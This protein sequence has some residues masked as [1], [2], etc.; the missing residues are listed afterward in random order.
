MASF[1]IQLP[2]G[3]SYN[4]EAPDGTTD[5]QAYMYLQQSL[6]AEGNQ[7]AGRTEPIEYGTEA[8]YES[9]NPS[10]QRDVADVGVQFV[11]GVNRAAGALVGLGSY[12]KGLNKI[13][14]PAAAWFNKVADTVDEGLLSDRQKE[15]NAELG[16]RLQAAAEELGPDASMGDYIDNMVSQGGEAGQYIADHPTQ[17]INLAVQSLPYIFGGGIAS[18]AAKGSAKLLGLKPIANLG[19]TGSAAMGEG[20]IVGGQAVTDVIA[21]TDSVGDYSAD[22][23]K[24]L[25]TIP[26]TM[27]ISMLGGKASRGLGI[28]DVDTLL[29]SGQGVKRIVS[30]AG[31]TKKVIGGGLIEGTE[32]LFQGAGEQIGVNYAKTEG[33]NILN[34][35][36]LEDVGG[37]AVIGAFTGAGQ[38][39]V[40][41]LA[42]GLGGNTELKQAADEAQATAAQEARQEA[43]DNQFAELASAVNNEADIAALAETIGVSVEELVQDPRF[44]EAQA[45][46]Q[47]AAEL[48]VAKDQRVKHKDTMPDEKEWYNEETAARE[49]RARIEVSDETTEMGAAFVQWRK[50]N[51]VYDT[52][53]AVVLDWIRNNASTE[54]TTVTKDDF[55]GALDAHAALAEVKATRSEE[56]QFEINATLEELLAQ[57]TEALESGDME[58]LRLVEQQASNSVDPTEWTETKREAAIRTAGLNKNKKKPKTAPVVEPNK[59]LEGS[60]PVVTETI[61]PETVVVP[62]ETKVKPPYKP[63]SKRDEKHQQAINTLGD[64]YK[65]TPYG[66]KVTD[67]I[68]KGGQTRFDKVL[69]TAL[70]EQA[71]DSIDDPKMRVLGQV[72]LDGR[73][74]IPELN[75][76]TWQQAV[77]PFLLE[78]ANRGALEDYM[79]D[80]ANKDGVK[81]IK[82]R[83][84]AIATELGITDPEQLK[85][86]GKRI[87]EA[88]DAYRRKQK[89]LG[90]L[91]GPRETVETFKARTKATMD[92]ARKPPGSKLEED[93]A[94]VEQE[95]DDKATGGATAAQEGQLDETSNDETPD[96]DENTFK[97]LVNKNQVAVENTNSGNISS[98]GGSQGETFALD[99][100]EQP[101]VE[102][103]AAKADPVYLRRQQGLQIERLSYVDK[104]HKDK[105]FKTRL[106]EEWDSQNNAVEGQPVTELGYLDQPAEVQQSWIRSL[107]NANVKRNSSQLAEAFNDVITAHNVGIAENVKLRKKQADPKVIAAKS[108]AKINQDLR[109]AK[110]KAKEVKK[111]KTLSKNLL[112]KA[113]T[114]KQIIDKEEKA[115]EKANSSRKS[116][117]KED[118]KGQPANLEGTSSTGAAVNKPGKKS[119]SS[120]TTEDKIVPEFNDDSKFNASSIVE[121]LADRKA[122]SPET[123]Q[124]MFL[125]LLGAR[126]LKRIA[127]RI[128]YFETVAEAKEKLNLSTVPEGIGGAVFTAK[129]DGQSHVVFITGNIAK[130]REQSTFMHEV[131]VHMGLENL[132][133]EES[134]A[135]I[136]AK[137]ISWANNP[138]DSLEKRIA[139]KAWRRVQNARNANAV[140]LKGENSEWVA[141]F[142]EEAV[143]AGVKP[144]AT[145]AAG[146]VLFK[147]KQAFRKFMNYK[148]GELDNLNTRDLVDLAYGASQMELGGT[149]KLYGDLKTPRFSMTFDEKIE[150]VI[151]QVMP[152]DGNGKYIPGTRLS[153]TEYSA[154]QASQWNK[155]KDMRAQ[156]KAEAKSRMDDA[157]EN[158]KNMADPEG[159]Q[160]SLPEPLTPKEKKESAAQSEE[161]KEALKQIPEIAENVIEQT[162][163]FAAIAKKA[164]NSVEFLHSFIDKAKDVMPSAVRWHNAYLEMEKTRYA[165]KQQVGAIA[166]RARQMSEVKR[167]QVNEFL[168]SSTVSQ[169]WGYDPEI[170]GKTVKVDSKMAAKFNKLDSGQQELVKEVFAHGELMLQRKRKIAEALGIKDQ[171]FGTKSLDGPYAPLKR[172]GNHVAEL[173]STEL[174]AA[175]KAYAEK[176]SQQNKDNLESLK[177]DSKHYI[178]SF[179]DTPGQASTFARQNK[180]SYEYSESFEREK[181]A[182]EGQTADYAVLQKVLG[183]L[184][185]LNLDPKSRQALEKMVNTMYLQS[186][187]DTNARQSQAKRKGTAGY[188]QD[189]IRSF[190]SHAGAEANL[191]ANMEHGK[192]INSALAEARK[193]K[194]KD[195]KNLGSIYNMIV[196]HY[197]ANMQNKETPVQDR[198]AALNTVYMLTSSVGYHLTNATQPQMVT[199]PK[200]AGDFG[201]YVRAQFLLARGYKVATK[202]VS[203]NLLKEG[204]GTEVDLTKVDPKYKLLLEELQLRQLL[205]VGMEQDLSEFTRFNTGVKLID[206]GSQKAANM[207]HKLY[208]VA[209]YVEAYNRVS[210]AVAAYD[211]ATENPARTKRMGMSPTEYAIG[212]VQD[213]QGNFSTMDAPLFIK[214][215][216]KLVVQYRKYQVMMAWVYAKAAKSVFAKASTPEERW[217][218][219]RT[220]GYLIGH[221]ALFGGFRGLPGMALVSPLYFA[222]FGEG[223]EPDDVE[224]AIRD[225]IQDETLATLISR[226]LPSVFGIDM[227]AKIGQENIFSPLPFVDFGL[228]QESLRDAVFSI[229]LGASG[230]TLSNAFRSLEYAKEGNTWRSIEYAIPKGFRHIMESWRLGTEGYSLRNGDIVGFPEDFSN[231]SLVLNSLGIPA[232]DLNKIKWTRNQQYELREYFNE[233]QS[234]IRKK[235]VTAKK[236]GNKTKMKKLRAEWR[237]LQQSKNRIRPF[238][239]DNRKSIPYT[240]IDSLILAPFKQTQREQNY[241]NELGTN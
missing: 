153:K 62:E 83:N 29:G 90:E 43:A 1:N 183:G 91:P 192:E 178:I 28:D 198:I 71:S 170:E 10:W 131:G 99:S 86:A 55:L 59:P 12:V 240:P 195:E 137:I 223:D 238:F 196:A 113:K 199:I 14:D 211:L 41:N 207:S 121:P 47:Q 179:F 38:G 72:P 140:D 107:A 94:Q 74:P 212:V 188:E 11:S 32:E 186:L 128:H 50:D 53:D 185:A 142:V 85:N 33:Y 122:S 116:E 82:W 2:N 124:E 136:A 156:L 27:A 232:T 95:A 64:D 139:Q 21:E 9:E 68:K 145:T 37:E 233:T 42:T 108:K 111:A 222:M 69:E 89:T 147:F 231:L 164:A 141:Y 132:L 229:G 78:A 60:S 88:V 8:S 22:R 24:A 75:N 120:D 187:D 154:F 49:E 133:G 230:S 18:K 155:E 35:K 134:I 171:F 197:N 220:L 93:M 219:A 57:R 123:F 213:T 177:L 52:N 202:I 80:G 149:N 172:F 204:S 239:N 226:G 201:N 5:E 13:A 58:Q 104:T 241:R 158:E 138:K 97:P 184:N 160:Y 215:W 119:T 130:G 208:Q 216:P 15:I 79:Y 87:N 44:V 152:K 40:V 110:K 205:D 19:R 65:D 20:L 127:N 73:K 148:T 125:V 63:G 203:M 7:A 224:R 143:I 66:A 217:V 159:I 117:R 54:E 70:L 221:A 182:S 194:K 98:V 39:S 3:K 115:N 4:I 193:E 81:E 237:T 225:R 210:A 165:I 176:D 166:V 175:E 17:V 151:N 161:F 109:R 105:K 96:S 30:G 227:S 76:K 67:A 162:E 189:M 45:A 157:A 114:A 34:P 235:Y 228:D 214:K 163:N 77:I 48:D 103:K 174:L 118:A 167:T 200:L 146:R 56:Q 190:L 101:F 51:D 16:T 100:A 206:G 150:A 31:T 46:K 129:D 36:L 236:E 26:S 6:G 135:E 218:G 106:I 126:G 112:N 234:S 173:K 169:Q 23:L 92:A 180:N 102:D 209:R 61:E 25:S 144:L 168:G 84:E 181:S 191:I